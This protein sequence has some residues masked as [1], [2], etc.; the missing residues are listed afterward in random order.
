LWRA[1]ASSQVETD[2]R[3]SNVAAWRQT[4]RNTISQEVFGQGLITDE[5]QQPAI[6]RNSIPAKQCAHG[7]LIAF[8]TV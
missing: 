3:D 2:E 1:I 5:P 4:S 6:Q 7:E 8:R